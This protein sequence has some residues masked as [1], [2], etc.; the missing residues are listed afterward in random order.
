MKYNMFKKYGYIVLS[1]VMIIN[2]ISNLKT[3][4]AAGYE[5]YVE[6]TL[7]EMELENE[8]VNDSE[9]ECDIERAL[10]RYTYDVELQ[11]LRY[12]MMYYIAQIRRE[13]MTNQYNLY[14]DSMP[15][16]L[17]DEKFLYGEDDI[18]QDQQEREK[19]EKQPKLKFI[20]E[21]EIKKI[22]RKKTNRYKISTDDLIN[23]IE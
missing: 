6:E 15:T 14:T 11:R 19:K 8:K 17:N 13:K 20:E 16:Q 9:D 18:C 23:Q 10:Q 4:A 7:E 5:D 12:E 22:D 2:F 1:N 21:K 3:F